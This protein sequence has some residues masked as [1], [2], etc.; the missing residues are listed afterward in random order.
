MYKKII[1][2][3]S[4]ILVILLGLF[5]W[6]KFFKAPNWQA[7]CTMEAKLC[8]DGSAVGRS[9]PNCE[10]SACPEV[11]K[12]N[13][14]NGWKTLTDSLQGISFKYPEKLSANFTS[15]VAW[16]PVVKVE[17]GKFICNAQ[18]GT[19]SLPSR[20]I[21][22]LVDDRVYCVEAM[23]EGAAGSTYTSYA[24]TT[25]QF[26]KLITLS[27]TLR[28]P[29]CLN[30]D[31]PQKTSCQ[32]ERESFDLDG[33]VDRMFQSIVFIGNVAA[34]A[35]LVK[36]DFPLVNQV[37]SSPLTVSGQ[38]RG[39]WFFEASF[40]VQLIDVDGQIIASGIAQA[41]GDWMTQEFVPFEAKLSFTP[42]PQSTKGLL[43]LKK[44]NPSGLPEHDDFLEMPVVFNNSN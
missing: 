33:V 11:V 18:D 40:P 38:A 24:Y 21:K 12:D 17:I 22:R 36:V 26:G 20:I 2:V 10:F 42:P 27:F 44:D 34:K 43:I 23:S 41:K 1:I 35:D 6:Q 25:A 5:V 19:A 4:L 30:Y 29:Q 14:D 8:P 13:P 39:V 16:P 32:N 9:G 15:T 37:V 3:V 28:Y 7:G 31:D